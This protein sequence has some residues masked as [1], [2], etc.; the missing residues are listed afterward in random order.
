[1]SATDIK[2]W[3][4]AAG[5][6][7]A[8]GAW[9]GRPE[10]RREDARLLTGGGLFVDDRAPDGCLYLEFFR[11]PVAS[12]RIGALDVS[13]ARGAPGVVSVLTGADVADLPAPA[14][15]TLLPDIHEPA[16]E[17]MG[18]TRA[19]A[20]G[21]PLAA[22]IATSQAAARDA[23]ELIEARFEPE[24]PTGPASPRPPRPRPPPVSLSPPPLLPPFSAVLES[25]CPDAAGGPCTRWRALPGAAG[26]SELLP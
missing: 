12:A 14:V 21:Q 16:F 13:A 3:R 8:S 7:E 15:N 24:A 20:V 1:M 4:V 18:A 9:I 19:A 17:L 2:G 26:G 23:A 6:D 25:S 5:A 11:S 10:R 22:V